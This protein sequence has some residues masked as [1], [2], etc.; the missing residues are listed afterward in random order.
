[1]ASF[2][3]AKLSS[4]DANEE[5]VALPRKSVESESDVAKRLDKRLVQGA[6]NEDQF[7]A[8]EKRARGL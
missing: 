1:M 2:P 8:L 5:I 4:T 6:V 7:M 3:V